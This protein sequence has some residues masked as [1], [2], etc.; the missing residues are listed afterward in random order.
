MLTKIASNKD[1][2]SVDRCSSITSNVPGHRNIAAFE[3][4]VRLCCD[5]PEPRLANTK[6]SFVYKFT[7]SSGQ[8]DSSLHRSDGERFDTGATMLKGNHNFIMTLVFWIMFLFF[9]VENIQARNAPADI[10]LSICVASTDGPSV[11]KKKKVS[12]TSTSS[13]S[14]QREVG[15]SPL[16]LSMRMT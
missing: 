13:R 1:E 9:G 5:M 15:R 16:T 3:N 4:R 8:Q 10:T 2:F 11:R 12:S 14:P 7:H 6:L